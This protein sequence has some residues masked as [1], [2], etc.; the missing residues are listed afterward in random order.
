M[1]Y[2]RGPV[3]SSNEAPFPILVTTRG[4]EMALAAPEPPQRI[5]ELDITRRLEEAIP[6]P[7]PTLS[8]E[9]LRI[10]QAMIPQNDQWYV[11]WGCRDVGHALYRCPYLSLRQQ[12]YFALQN[13]R[14]QRE[15]YPH[16]RNLLDQRAG[17]ASGRNDGRQV[18]WSD[19][20]NTGRN[21]G[22]GGGNYGN[23]G[24]GRNYGGYSGYGGNRGGD[25]AFYGNRQGGYDGR[26]GNA[27]SRDGQRRDEREAPKQILRRDER[28]PKAVREET[29]ND[30]RNRF[31]DAVLTL[32]ELA[33]HPDIAARFAPEQEPERRPHVP[34][35]DASSS[36]SDSGREAKKG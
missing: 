24:Y 5:T 12:L 18:G 20:R 3:E 33:L 1:L 21:D 25:R 28:H 34:E 22:R 8:A 29:A 35:L 17:V 32:Q 15:A 6:K 27:G 13:Y 7:I 9:E 36:D 14:Y 2:K 23:S 4:D 16:S 31:A 26:D 19:R 10:A 11:C 30:R